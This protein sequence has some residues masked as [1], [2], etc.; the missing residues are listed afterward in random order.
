LV[1]GSAGEHDIENGQGLSGLSG[2]W[3][4]SM[5]GHAGIKRHTQCSTASVVCCHTGPLFPTD[6]K[7][8][9]VSRAEAY[10]GVA[11]CA[12]THLEPTL[13]ARPWKKIIALGEA[14]LTALTGKKGILV[15]RGS[16][17]PLRGGQELKVIPT[18]E[19][20]YL[21]R[22]S[23]YVSVTINDFRKNPTVVPERYALYCSAAGL[24]DG[25][26]PRFAF[27][28]EWDHNGDISLCGIS[29]RLYACRVAGWNG[30][31]AARAK[32]VFEAATDLI[33]H[34]IIGADTVMFERLGWNITAR[35][36]DT[37]LKQHLLQPDF[38][39]G[40]GFV[41]S[42]YTG[43]IFWKGKG[44]ESE[45]EAGELT[46][47][48]IQW[49]TW[50]QPD[51][52]P[53]ELGGYGGCSSA[54]EAYRL[55][56]ARDTDASY[57]INEALDPELA[58]WGLDNVYW[59]VSVPAAFICRD[60]ASRGVKVHS[61]RVGELRETLSKDIA[62][63]EQQ[64]PE[65]LKPYEQPITKQIPAPPGTYKPQEKTC[66]GTKKTPHDPITLRW[67]SPD[68]VEHSNCPTC[69][70]PCKPNKWQSIKKI[71]IAATERIVPWNSSPQV[72]R[73]ANSLG[74]KARWDRKRGSYAADSLAR[75]GW[76][77]S[78]SEFKILDHLKELSTL[79]SNFA[80]EELKHVSRMYFN[81]L[82]HGTAEGRFSSSG[83]RKGID[84]N[85]QNQ[86]ASFRR[87]YI[88]DT[89]AHAFLELDYSGGENWLTAFLAR[90]EDRLTRLGQPGY[91]EHLHL[92]QTL[93][94]LGDTVGKTAAKSWCRTCG[95]QC[96]EVE[97]APGPCESCGAVGQDLYDVA[98]HVNH[99]G[100]YGMTHV[101]QKE[102]CDALECY[103]T[104]REHKAFI[105]KREGMNPGTTRW[106]QATIGLA[107]RDGYLRNP[108]GRMRWFSSRNAKTQALAFLPA[109]T[110]ADIIIRAMIAHYPNRFEKECCALGL[111]VTGELLPGVEIRMQIHDSLVLHGPAE[112]MVEQAHRTKAVMEQ[113]WKELDGFKLGVECKLGAA[114]ASW[115]ELEK[116]EI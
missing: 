60:I 56:N 49:K 18:L 96:P 61:G 81:L 37:M 99:G 45:D 94:S 109:S 23:K 31:V 40:L 47:T 44:K 3:I 38:R 103:F 6:P 15:W 68:S 115:G 77:R 28:L 27:D 82:V 95:Q 70:R 65:G 85:I 58:R 22:D 83:K 97:G 46:D 55:Y 100:N 25:L 113:P 74:L 59:N 78:H 90:D 50:D 116:L 42:V 98:K 57:Q 73:Y 2:S 67:T 54:D 84:L 1:Q 87:I 13:R 102:Y 75:K 39:H 21:A 26:N 108:F 80:K 66:K 88:P 33:G 105:A 91:S 48:K 62:R 79:R 53:R 112:L 8:R 93:F 63:I 51:A 19:P 111:G 106:Q 69:L 101:K 76:G 11:Y 107:E 30:E 7:W 52:I 29:D 4:N 64:L 10:A 34:N 92:A 9:G 14:P 5:L 43:K 32:G 41:G 104:E 72:T 12:R 16:P 20:S 110:L 89:P 86:P 17:L 24:L 114:G 35:M 71:K 36:H